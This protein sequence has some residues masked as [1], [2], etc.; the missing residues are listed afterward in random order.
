MKI[1][2]ITGSTRGIGYGL[3]NELLKQ[4]CAVSI[5]GRTAASV[6]QAVSALA[7]KF[8]AERVFGNPCD[9]T[10]YLEVL[11]LWE[12][13]CAHFGKIDIWINNAG[14]GHPPAAIWELSPDLINAV[15]STNL[16]G[17]FYGSKVAV[18]GMMAQG[19]GSLYNMEGRGSNGARTAGLALYGSTKYGLRYLTESLIEETKGSP[20]LVGALSPG[21]V[22][23]DL[24]VGQF[25]R[26][27]KSLGTGK[28][29]L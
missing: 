10:D 22:V 24:L 29:D 12:K 5:S 25:R 21:M 17:A 18:Q 4:G 13:T 26:P 28:T 20:I 9:V 14:L 3:A 7:G 11:T 27:T 1:V 16:I 15:I 23:T 19:Y 2:V 8:G 6:A